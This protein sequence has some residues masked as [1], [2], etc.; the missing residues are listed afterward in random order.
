MCRTID[1]L[2]IAPFRMPF[3]KS[4]ERADRRNRAGIDRDYGESP[5][6]FLFSAQG[7]CRTG[8]V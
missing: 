5:R 3:R 2:A 4:L 1:D 6:P 7:F 8:T